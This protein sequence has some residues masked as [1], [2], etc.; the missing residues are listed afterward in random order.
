MPDTTD[1]GL[2]KTSRR[3]YGLDEVRSSPAAAPAT[4]T[5]STPAGRSTP[6]ASRSRSSPRAWTASSA[7]PPPSPSASWARRG[8]QPRGHLDPARRPRGAPRRDRRAARGRGVAP[9]PRGLRPA[10]PPRAHPRP[11][12]GD[13]RR[14]GVVSCGSVTPHR[15]E[16]LADA[17]VAAEL[18]LL[19]IQGTVV[20]A[21]HV[22]KGN[23]EPLNLKTFVRRARPP[24]DRRRLLQLPGCPPPDAHRRRRDPR[25]RRRRVVVVHPGDPRAWGVAQA[26]AIADARAARMRHLDETGVVRATSSPTAGCAPA[27]T[28]PRPW[29][30]APT[31]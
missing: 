31:R 20:S 4:S 22:T 1:I 25:R 7:R 30:A 26:T 3:A 27:A 9:A 18:D 28:S 8:P 23:P 13:P 2:G 19:V 6:S 14:R 15:V 11:G 24:G 16:A 17:L 10:D 12:E 5:T 21:E 29:C